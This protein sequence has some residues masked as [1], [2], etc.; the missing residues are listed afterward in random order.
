MKPRNGS[1]GAINPGRKVDTMGKES[2][3]MA[4]VPKSKKDAIYKAWRDDDGLWI[5]LKDGWSAD[6]TDIGCK[7][8]HEDTVKELRYQ[9]AG[10]RKL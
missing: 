10:I 8:I 2:R 1:P 5:V 9:I 3:I 4:Y 7:T 6:R